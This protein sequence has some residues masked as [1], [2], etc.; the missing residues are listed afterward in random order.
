MIHRLFPYP[1]VLGAPLLL[2]AIAPIFL[3]N[4][5]APANPVP[6]NPAPAN[7]T[8][9]DGQLFV[10]YPPANHE[11]TASRIFLI[12]TAPPTGTVL[13]N[14]RVIQRSRAGHFAPSV[15]LQIGM[16]QV[17]LQY[18]DQTVLIQVKR[19]PLGM[20]MPTGLEFG[21]NS[22]TPAVA[23]ARPVGE[24]VCFGAIASP[25][26]TVTVTLAGQTIPLYLDPSQA[27][28][29]EN[30]AVLTR[31]NA[32]IAQASGQFRGCSASLRPGE[33]GTPTF[34]LTLGGKSLTQAGPAPVTVL[35]VDPVT[36][37]VVTAKSGAARTGPSTDYSRLTPLPQGTRS[38][39]TAMEGDWVRLDYGA[40]IKKSEVQL[41][42]T[43]APPRSRIRSVIAQAVG[44]WT[45][46]R[47][48]LEVPVPMSVQQQDQ[49]LTLTLFNTTAQTDTTR[50]ADDSVVRRL[51]WQQ[52]APGQVQYLF[53]MKGPQQWGYKLRYEGT[54]LVLSLKH[55][56]R[57]AR[58]MP[59]T[60]SLAGVTILLDPGHGGPEDLG[61]RGPTGYPEKAVALII[62][63]LV[64]QELLRRGAKVVMT[65][66]SDV[67]VSLADR[68]ALINQVE[69]TLALSLHYNALPDSG[70]A[71]KTA[72]VGLFWYHPQAHG[73][74]MFLQ[75][76]LTQTLPRPSY[77]V[78]WNN[79]ALTRPTV[80]PAVL[81]ELGFMINPDEFE[82]ITN[83]QD[84]Q[85]LAGAIADG[86]T[87]WLHQQTAPIH[88]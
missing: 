4:L 53:H 34:Q 61:A 62:S 76:A 52:I 58:G 32:P 50:L 41:L 11:T 74:A 26:A 35:P 51:D 27:D 8:Q 77:G 46:V 66:D 86:I 59:S 24:A 2:G 36:L 16:N 71:E 82:W 49:T 45:E 20:T 69:P 79:L 85:R 56:P 9:G 28:L 22:L 40:W 42:P 80:A 23:V 12:G 19:L 7:P 68:V 25:Q 18:Q 10:A 5:P 47:F 67:D 6:V 84:Q 30:A 29:P 65:R 54:T 33:W 55:P 48:P 43:G 14:G 64:R 75:T 39:V 83:P 13:V 70:N 88:P 73:L 15:P 21:P 38:Q 81:L 87:G 44:E 37:A 57:V 63:Q 3:A 60:R 31:E 1:F 17:R 78:F 72:G